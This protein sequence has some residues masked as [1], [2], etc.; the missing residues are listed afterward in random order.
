MPFQAGTCP[1]AF[2]DVLDENTVS[3]FNTQVIGQ[4]LDTI[5]GK[6][7]VT[8]DD[9]S[10]KLEVSFEGF[11]EGKICSIT[12]AGP[13]LLMTEFNLSNMTNFKIKIC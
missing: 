13:P 6:A 2:Y 10:A 8:S 12:N 9:N 3:V 1:N 7:V 4:T 5:V 11:V